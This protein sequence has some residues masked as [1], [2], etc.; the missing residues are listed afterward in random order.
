MVHL[1]VKPNPQT[2]ILVRFRGLVFIRGAG[3][4]WLVGSTPE[5]A[6]RVRALAGD[7]VLWTR[8]FTLTVHLSTQVYT[9]ELLGKP[10]KIAGEWP[11]MD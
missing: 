10:D 8:H 3:A 6:V 9:G 4:S 1:T 2:E 11:V 7:N 5:R